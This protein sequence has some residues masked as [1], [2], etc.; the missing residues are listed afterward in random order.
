MALSIVHRLMQFGCVAAI[1]IGITVQSAGAQTTQRYDPASAAG[2][3]LRLSTLEDQVR[4]LNG[5]IEQMS[6]QM[7]QLQDQ[8]VRMSQDNEYRFQTMGQ[9]GSTQPTAPQQP[10]VPRQ[11]PQQQAMIISPSG[12]VLGPAPGKPMDLTEALGQTTPNPL[13]PQ[14]SLGSTGQGTN[15]QGAN[16]LGSTAS[17]GQPNPQ[18]ALAPLTD[19]KTAYDQSYRYVLRGQFDQAE[20][21]LRQFMAQYPNDPLAS[22]AQYWLGESLYARGKYRN[23]ADAFLKG[24][25]DYPDGAKAPDSLYKLGMSLKE[26]G[27]ADAACSTFSEIGRRYPRA[28]QAV[29][30]RTR[31]ELQKI[32]C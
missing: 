26:L 23:A 2:L 14:P 12:Q 27:Q 4:Q 19:P 25:S 30:E 29:L 24:Y 6:H 22:N 8:L 9:A 17:S 21:S 5:Q 16:G 18:Y 7:R 31:N 11:P 28:S 15:G 3:S 1:A 10:A 13:F 32:G 20:V